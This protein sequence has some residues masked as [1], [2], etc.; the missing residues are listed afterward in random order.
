[1]NFIKYGIIVA[2]SAALFGIETKTI[3]SASETNN[4]QQTLNVSDNNS[5]TTSSNNNPDPTND[6]SDSQTSSSE[7]NNLESAISQSL[8]VNSNGTYNYS[9]NQIKKIISSYDFTKINKQLGTN[10]T[11]DGFLNDVISSLKE[12]DAPSNEDPLF[13]A[14]LASG[15]NKTRKKWNYTKVYRTHSRTSKVSADYN[16]LATN[17]GGAGG[18][19]QALDFLGPYGMALG[20]AIGGTSA[21]NAWYWQ[22]FSNSLERNNG[23]KGTITTMNRFVPTF[24]VKAQ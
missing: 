16:Q 18:V 13:G 22:T 19:S 7:F 5:H 8:S 1:M 9:Q 4:T 10:L 24:K 14:S 23:K 21:A 15:I 20:F 17:W 6:T 11:K 12:T 3:C 2:S